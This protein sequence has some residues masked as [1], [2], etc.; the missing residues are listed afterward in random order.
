SVAYERVHKQF[1]GRLLIDTVQEYSVNAEV[2]QSRRGSIYI[3]TPA[4]DITMSG[5][6]SISLTGS[7][8]YLPSKSVEG[9]LTLTGITVQP[10]KGKMR[11]KNLS[12]SISQL[13]KIVAKDIKLEVKI[14]NM[15][16]RYQS[17]VDI[18]TP[19]LITKIQSSIGVKGG[20]AFVTRTTL[21]YIVPKVIRDKVTVN[22]KGNLAIT[23]ALKMLKGTLNVVFK[24]RPQYNIDTSVEAS[25]TRKK[26]G[27]TFDM[28][29]GE[30]E[31]D[32][33][34]RITLST[35]VKH[36]RLTWPESTLSTDFD[37]KHLGMGID[38]G[39]RTSHTHDRKQL[40]TSV[41]VL[42]D[43]ENEM[44]ATLRLKNKSKG[45]KNLSGTLALSYGGE[46][47]EVGN[48][49]NEGTDGEF[50]NT[51]TAQWAQSKRNTIV[52]TFRLPSTHE[53]IGSVDVNLADMKRVRI[54][55]Q[56]LL[57]WRNMS[58]TTEVRIAGDIYALSSSYQLIRGKSS[59]VTDIKYPSRHI[60]FEADVTR[61]LPLYAVRTNL[62]WDANRDTSKRFL[63]DGQATIE[64]INTIDITA[65]N[66]S[67][68]GVYTVNLK[69]RGGNNYISHADIEWGRSKRITVD[70]TFSNKRN[71]NYAATLQI[72]SPFRGY[73]SIALEGTH[74][75]DSSRYSTSL[76]VDWKPV[77]KISTTVTVQKPIS[78]SNFEGEV[79]VK[80]PVKGFQRTTFGVNHKFTDSLSSMA[81][82]TWNKN[83]VQLNV[84]A[85][86]KG[87]SSIRDVTGRVSLKTT[88]AQIGSM[89]IGGRHHD[90]G[91]R[92]VNNFSVNKDGQGLAYEGEMTH[93]RSGWQVQNNGRLSLAV[94]S[95]SIQS[96]WDHQNTL[97]DVRT[98][99]NGN[100]GNKNIE[101]EL[102]GNQNLAIERG[103]ASLRMELRGNVLPTLAI[104]AK[105]DHASGS[106][107]NGLTI[108]RNSETLVSMKNVFGN[109]NERIGSTHTMEVMNEVYAVKFDCKY[110]D[111]PYTGA[112]RLE[113]TP[114]KSITISTNLNQA[115]GL[116]S[117]TMSLQSP[118]MTDIDIT[119]NQ[120]K[121]AR[122]LINT[123]SIHYGSTQVLSVENRMRMDNSKRVFFLV[124]SGLEDVPRLETNM[125]FTGDLNAFQASA[126][127]ELE[128]I[129]SRMSVSSQWN[130]QGDIIGNLRIDTPFAVLPY[131]QLTITSKLQGEERISVINIEYLPRRILKLE[132]SYKNLPGDLLG[133]LTLTTPFEQLP[134]V[135]GMAKFIGNSRR[136]RSS[137]ALEDIHGQ[138]YEAK[139]SFG[140]ERRLTGELS[141]KAPHINDIVAM[142][143]HE[144]NSRQLT[145][146]G[147]LTWLN[148]DRYQTV[149]EF[150][151]E[152]KLEGKVILKS[153]HFEDI[154]L[155]AH[156]SGNA[157]RFQS[158][159]ML[160]YGDQ[161][162]E[163]EIILVNDGNLE[164][165]AIL[166][167]PFTG[168]MSAI[169]QHNGN[170]NAF[171]SHAEVQYKSQKQ[172]EA[173]ATFNNANTEGTL[174][175]KSPMFRPIT[176]LFNKNGEWSN[177]QSHGELQYQT[178]SRIVIDTT[179]NIVDRIEGSFRIQTPYTGNLR[180]F[181]CH[182]ELIY[183]PTKKI[184]G[185]L[186]FVN[187]DRK[188]A[189]FALK[190]PFCEDISSAIQLEMQS[191]LF[192]THVEAQYGSEKIQGD[193]SLGWG[194]RKLGSF[195]LKTPFTEDM[196]AAFDHSGNWKQ[197]SSHAE[198]SLSPRDKKY[199]ADI[200]FANARKIKATVSV[201]SKHFENVNLAFTNRG[202][203]AKFNN[204]MSAQ[205]GED[206]LETDLTFALR[207][208]VS[209][210]LVVTTP[211][212]GLRKLQATIKHDGSWEAFNSKA[213][214]AI[215]KSKITASAR[216]TL[217]PFSAEIDAQTPFAGFKQI[218]A[219]LSHVGTFSRFQSRAEVTYGKQKSITGD[220]QF[221]SQPLTGQVIITTPF[222]GYETLKAKMTHEGSNNVY[223]STININLPRKQKLS[224]TANMDL[225]S[226]VSAD[227]AV[228]TPFKGYQKINAVFSHTGSLSNFACH[229][230]AGIGPR[231][232]VGDA[233]FSMLDMVS[234]EAT[235]TTPFRG[236]KK[237][238][239]AFS[240]DGSSRDFRSHVEATLR[241]AKHEVDLA[242]STLSNVAGNLV[243]KSPYVRTIKATISHSGNSRGLTSEGKLVRG[244]TEV[245]SGQ[246][247]FN[248]EPS[249][250]GTATVKSMWTSPAIVTFSHSGDLQNFNSQIDAAYGDS[251]VIA[252]GTLDT[253]RDIS[254]SVSVRSPF[255]PLE[256]VRATMSHAGSFLNGRYQVGGSYKG[257]EVEAIITVDSETKKEV[258]IDIST[259]FRDYQH[260]KAA[261]SHKCTDEMMTGSIEM[262]L[263]EDKVESQVNVNMM[264]GLSGRFIVRSPWYNDISGELSHSGN[265]PAFTTH[266]ELTYSGMKQFMTDIS[267]ETNPR[268]TMTAAITTPWEQIR[269][270]GATA[271]H[272]GSMED[273]SSF[274][275][276][277]RNDQRMVGEVT[278][279]SRDGL[280]ARVTL[281]TPFTKD[282]LIT[283]TKRGT[284][285]NMQ[286][287]AEFTYGRVKQVELD[288]SWDLTS[289]IDASVILKTPVEGF[290]NLLF[291]ISHVGGMNGFRS[292]LVTVYYM[293]QQIE[294]EA[295]FKNGATQEATVVFTSPFTSDFRASLVKSSEETTGEV[296]Y[297]QREKLYTKITYSTSPVVEGS[298]LLR[299]VIPG[300]ETLNGALRHEGSFQTTKS[301]AE[302]TINGQTSQVDVT[303]KNGFKKQGSVRIRTPMTA[304]E[305][306]GASFSH[307]LGRTILESAI[308]VNKGEQQISA[309][310]SLRWRN[311]IEGSFNIATPFMKFRNVRGSFTHSGTIQQFTCHADF[312]YAP[313][314]KLSGDITF[315][316]TNAFEGSVSIN[317]PFVGYETM[318]AAFRHDFSTENLSSHLEISYQPNQKLEME[319]TGSLGDSSRGQVVVRTPFA[320][321]EETTGSFSQTLRPNGYAAHLEA[322]YSQGQRLEMN[323]NVSPNEGQF[324]L[325]TPFP[326]FED[327]SAAFN[328]EWTSDR[329]S[330]HA[331]A[332]Y[333]GQ[334][335]ELDIVLSVSNGKLVIKTPL[336]G[337]ED[338]SASFTHRGTTE[339]FVSHADISYLQ[340]QKFAVDVTFSMRNGQ[341]SVMTPFKG[342]EQIA[343]AFTNANSNDEMSGSAEM[344]YSTGRKV[345][346][347]FTLSSTAGHLTVKTPF[348]G[349]EEITTAF[350]HQFTSERFTGKAKISPKPN[351][352]YEISMDL[353]LTSG[354]LTIK[355]PLQ[356][357]EMMSAAFTNRK[358]EERFTHQSELTYL[359]GKKLELDITMSPSD[360]SFAV[361]T[362]FSGY[363]QLSAA[364][365][366]QMAEQNMD[367]TVEVTYRP[368]HKIKVSA[369]VSSE[370]GQVTIT[371]PFSGYEEMT[372]AFTNQMTGNNIATHAEITYLPGRKL[373][374]DFSLSPE[375]GQITVMT[376]FSGYEEM[377]AAFTNQ[378]SENSITAH[379]E[380]TYLPGRKLQADVSLSLENGHIAI[381]TP[382]RGYE[383][384]SA[385]FT[386]QMTE[387][388]IAAHGEMT[389]LPGK[390]LQA[391]LSLSPENGQLVIMTPFSGYEE[392][393]AA[394]TNQMTDN[395]INTHGEITYLPGRKLQVDVSLSLENGHIIIRTPFR[396]YEEMS[397]SFTNQINGES[398]TN[399]VQIHY[400]PGKQIESD[401]SI[402]P[403]EGNIVLRTPFTGYEVL[404]TAYRQA[405]TERSIAGYF[406]IS[407]KQDERFEVDIALSTMA[408]HL[409]VK[410]PFEGYR[411]MTTSFTTDVS[412]NT[413]STKLQ[414]SLTPGQKYEADVS[415]SLREGHV[416]VKTPIT[417]YEIFSAAYTV[418]V[419]RAK[420]AFHVEATDPTSNK[421]ELDVNASFRDRV[422][423][424]V[425]VKTPFTGYEQLGLT[426]SHVMQTGNIQSS[427]SIDYGRKIT[428]AARMTTREGLTSSLTVKTPFDGYESSKLTFSFNKNDKM[429]SSQSSVEFGGQKGEYDLSFA[430]KP[431]IDASFVL[432]TPFTGFEMTSV[433]FQHVIS[434][435]NQQV[436]ARVLYSNQ[437]QISLDMTLQTSDAYIGS[438]SLNT[439]FAGFE[440]NTASFEVTL[441]ESGLTSNVA[442]AIGERSIRNTLSLTKN[443]NSVSASINL[444]TPFDHFEN[445]GLRLNA[446][447]SWS[448]SQI[449]LS[450]S[451]DDTKPVELLLKHAISGDRCD[452]SFLFRTLYYPELTASVAHNGNWRS[453]SNDIQLAAGRDYSLHLITTSRFSEDLVDIS[454][455]FTGL[456]N[457]QMHSVKSTINHQGPI[458]NFRTNLKNTFNGRK[459]TVN[460]SFRNAASIDG[461]FSM[462]TP[463]RLFRNIGASLQH[464]GDINQF[465][466]RANIQLT[467]AKIIAANVDFFK[468]HLRRIN[469]NV[470]LTSPFE[471]LELTKF[472]YRHTVTSNDI[473]CFSDVTYGTDK[474]S[475]AL[476]ASRSPLS[477][478]V[479]FQTPFTDY[480]ELA[481]R[482]KYARQGLSHNINM[483]LKYRTGKEIAFKSSVDLAASPVTLTADLTTPFAGYELTELRY[484]HSGRFPDF[485]CN[486]EFS[487]SYSAPINGEL[488]VRFGSISDMETF[489]TFTSPFFDNAE[490]LRFVLRNQKDTNEYQSHTEVAW[491][492]TDVIVVDGS[493]ARSETWNGNTGS[494]GLTIATPF[495]FLRSGGA[496]IHHELVSSKYTETMSAQWNGEKMLDMDVVFGKDTSYVAGLTMRAPQP[497]ALSSKGQLTDD[498]IGGEMNLNWN[499]DSQDSNMMLTAA[500][501]DRSDSFTTRKEASLTV[502]N[503]RNAVGVTGSLSKSSVAF[504]SSGN[505]IIDGVNKYGIDFNTRDKARR[506]NKEQSISLAIRIPSRT[507]K[508]TG[509]F[510]D[511]YRVKTTEAAIFWDA[512]RDETKTIGVIGTFTPQGRSTKADFSVSFPSIG[513]NVK[514]DSEVVMNSGNIIFDGKTEFSYSSD[515]SK[516]FV[517]HSRVE[518]LSS[519]FRKNYTF[520]VGVSH[521]ATTVDIQ[522]TSHLAQIDNKYSAR[523]NLDYLTSSRSR[524]N[525]VL[526]G[527]IDKMRKQMKVEMVSPVKSMKLSG[528]VSTSVPYRL[529][530]NNEYDER[531]INAELIADPS[532][533]SMAFHMN[534]DIDT[535]GKMFH[536]EAKYV[537][538]SAIRAEV[539]REENTQRITDSLFAMRL[540]TSR[541]L[542]SR[543][544][545]RPTI[546][547]DL[548]SYGL[549]RMIRNSRDLVQLYNEIA[550]GLNEEVNSKYSIIRSAL[551]Q[552]LKPYVQFAAMNMRGI[553][554]DV[555]SMRGLT[556]CAELNSRIEELS[557][558]DGK[559]AA[560]S[561][562]S[563][564]MKD[565]IDMYIVAG[566]EMLLTMGEESRRN[567]AAMMNLLDEH[568]AELSRTALLTFKTYHDQWTNAIAQPL[569]TD[570][571]R[572]AKAKYNEYLTKLTN[573][574]SSV[575]IPQRYTSA[576]YN[577]REQ[578]N[579]AL[580]GLLDRPEINY[581]QSQVAAAYKYWEV[582]ENA[583]AAAR[584]VYNHIMEIIEEEIE[585]L[586]SVIT[587]LEKT[588]ITVFDIANGEVQTDTYLIVPMK[589]LKSLPGI[590]MVHHY[591]KIRSFIPDTSK[592]GKIVDNLPSSDVSTWMPPFDVYGT[593]EGNRFTTFDGKT[594]QFNG[595]CSYVL[596]GDYMDGNF[597]IILDYMGKQ[598]RRVI[599][600]TTQ[601][602][603]QL[604]PKNKLRVDG[605]ITEMP[606]H[607]EDISVINEGD[608]V[609][610]TGRGFTVRHNQPTD[611]YDIGLSGWYFGK[612]GG[613]LGTY[614]NE[615]RD[616][617]MM[618]SRQLTNDVTSFADSW[619][620]N[621]RCR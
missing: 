478:D 446:V 598:K 17:K 492:Q 86:N 221:N 215:G 501:N 140:N 613:L 241:K 333:Q 56:Y 556:S 161:T 515:E 396:G 439:P 583:K 609:T 191:A 45:T 113:W 305:D 251:H 373:Q 60:T 547:Q 617:L 91:T 353:S 137:I 166:R 184:E 19:Y 99:L 541:M 284:L 52:S 255:Y 489:V 84:D 7:V 260:M 616:D 548:K 438:M 382:F 379:G 252:E 618:P 440:S 262:K 51:L 355:T 607:T 6:D 236:F 78:I 587:D 178:G 35:T 487:A 152:G 453:F 427:A 225:T 534:Y 473:K 288:G 323:L 545:W 88:I 470:E 354:Q 257:E 275:E 22:G 61:S 44:S 233:R 341:L 552:E 621:D 104:S 181:Q 77:K 131:S 418:T 24:R 122:E 205:Y 303:F 582:E 357:Y 247:N 107:T 415:L 324:A 146:H 38:V 461:S 522:L 136:F 416:I 392:M 125:L 505:I 339:S 117:G 1:Q 308:Q 177:F 601:H 127:F 605:A 465:T 538:S 134:R 537:N 285:I 276:L 426:I 576:I 37:L 463:F 549:Q 26:T 246:L 517:L 302:F 111:F 526:M 188:E 42:P 250:T 157:Q 530:I 128:P 158:N 87:T 100:Y 36:P 589:S 586:K 209:T 542:H 387:D 371:T 352:V 504:S 132:N 240:M 21:D 89:Y 98:S 451:Y 319:V 525:F 544:H 219:S 441:S 447:G 472:V 368:E 316:S 28:G 263:N 64:D 340:Q 299:S 428:V 57:T 295:V 202:R 2:R 469:A 619:E 193:V 546:V 527:E 66:K 435:D 600:T 516:K 486:A 574:L 457:G 409:T 528:Q 485:R 540:N 452:A 564:P 408:G 190:T 365:T 334:K 133:S 14:R 514:L 143:N 95:H 273:F 312:Q 314:K 419:N 494:F 413:A 63:V 32:Q 480:E 462:K 559:T 218:G 608:D 229:A 406:A 378:M 356:G 92:F 577:R 232:I 142:I 458:D 170:I 271:R 144:G 488:T 13:S 216:F 75:S 468:H 231:T 434:V 54:S 326:G 375:N 414:F 306:I 290:N 118:V 604:L 518:D 610:V 249:V 106:L 596:A 391:D 410:T 27:L 578:I 164:C 228:V 76:D 244:V 121:E 444:Q 327:I 543:L 338:M 169:I 18:T 475:G 449:D 554:Q 529:F 455:T 555:T 329:I 187:A 361:H 200:T 360:G 109:D 429:V 15:G 491:T 405:V 278:I 498:T 213:T 171:Q 579:S 377:S 567:Y 388:S 386:N 69:H 83:L 168:D 407:F 343:A 153:P 154:T 85:A 394:F 186:S 291:K 145:S 67:P 551:L 5:R 174:K 253:R 114:R 79:V 120:N 337:Y 433:T 575:N 602:A 570:V 124:T 432:K 456:L 507:V 222:T 397:V 346:I 310:I 376:P 65:N 477:F 443:D 58:A 479:S 239:V 201:K 139:T 296:Y 315:S 30:N 110:N 270:I 277:L 533:L 53:L 344:T 349:Y 115:N 390:K 49:L 535:P 499:T 116:L 328:K 332:A 156:H 179:F 286:T 71:N 366:H 189:S 123:G 237:T 566:S 317:T 258:V 10:V 12:Q 402:S 73:R 467:P 289:S 531:P 160:L 101:M 585:S 197:F 150:T 172:F 436:H 112:M 335:M 364:F 424:N 301:H 395:N 207:P 584:S 614:N 550:T 508:T 348:A 31:N 560:S 108:E 151:R 460:V 59:I 393:S 523:M 599:I 423:C 459:S 490:T 593:V 204:K 403:R 292:N 90:D 350:T 195:A 298:F 293:N 33:N 25:H 381:R 4:V 269:T 322:V 281:S 400:Q 256:D 450:T 47:I 592:W 212:K 481:A 524:K 102:N 363:E 384:M 175:L 615:R 421:V 591:N 214:A 342:Y 282:V 309:D 217:S 557:Q 521:P 182:A 484:T 39:F 320:G 565:N 606:Y 206:K 235:L 330:G 210:V 254:G 198:L 493:F 259:P 163:M 380:I 226:G 130:M 8:E 420:F 385:A 358:T 280:D 268:V 404:S 119:F 569:N 265:F 196:H 274:L 345:E 43:R 96:S 176:V 287:H 155:T 321:Y 597:S 138:K 11:G 147:Q 192:S 243:I 300:M 359:P 55:G 562:V 3:Y 248:T 50:T 208:S 399:H 224:A 68:L 572:M 199:E 553:R 135:G 266:G 227:L 437:K 238:R 471:G 367:T 318:A 568:L 464:S 9:D 41:T 336:S 588:K 220:L 80:C 307:K 412:S 194:V 466:T 159:A 442:A 594:Y 230:E 512:E 369:S 558:L 148:G 401:I 331:E 511:A 372:A 272:Q 16:K 234:G 261:L 506:S 264:N 185:D 603:V 203:L 173:D 620:V 362:P 370:S 445:M 561:R 383:E 29:Y 532:K 211:F 103:T 496:S 513:K 23:K 539:Y 162:S 417:G 347:E 580:Y 267:L 476:K 482:A 509:L 167:S 82:F 141:L 389:Y 70:T 398:I 34:K 448:D 313:S 242:L 497:V 180:N 165:S 510:R 245:V 351:K 46:N 297:N 573:R 97:S 425:V 612:T 311:D 62:L 430:F 536:A 94:Q 294:M 279:N 563:Y 81:K 500:L 519:G 503:S 40:E 72:S 571:V 223:Q 581:M 595:R 126:Y 105:H 495:S 431:A 20:K 422:K 74:L 374:A 149:V 93:D 325:R 483:N 304:F 590:D 183:H 474:V 48:D 611:M 520:V 502:R 129:V 454:S 283:V 411:V